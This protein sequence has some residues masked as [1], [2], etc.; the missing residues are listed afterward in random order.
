MITLEEARKK[1]LNAAGILNSEKVNFV[2]SLGMVLA[3][4]IHSPFNIPGFDRAAMDGYA[5]IS[6]DVADA[7][8]QNPV[9]L[10]MIADLPAGGTTSAKIKKDCCIRIMTGAPMPEGADAVVM[11]EDVKEKSCKVEK[12]E[13]LIFKDVKKE[14]NVAFAGEDV[15]KG[16]LILRRGTLIRAAQL[17]MLA[18]LGKTKVKVARKP[19]VAVIS[20][21]DEI[22]HPG[23]KLKSGQIYDSNSYGLCSQVLECGGEPY[24]LGIARD[25]K[26]ILLRKILEGLKFDI[27]L[28]SGGVSESVYD[29]VVSVLRKAGV[30]MLF[31]KVAVKPGKPTFFGK[32]GRT[33]VFGLPGYPVSSMLSF[34]SLVRPAILKI[35]G[36]NS[37]KKIKI[38]TI[39]KESIKNK[40]DRTSLIRVKLI[41]K[42]GEYCAIPAPS[43]KS[44]ALKS[45]VWANGI[46]SLSPGSEIKKGRE[47]SVELL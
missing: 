44:G 47:V 29:M 28:L 30:R 13:I 19:R 31:W 12:K 1:V 27:L 7:T 24:R 42:K 6:T 3:E 33:L 37:L 21:G 46:I 4:D 45:L 9:M 15:K 36:N 34:E 23:V 18:A 32:K 11:V 22:V 39:L 38:K 8:P 20:T 2:S 25:N 41:E 40:G 26:K 43:Q 10:R 17:A 35:L 14:E 5:V 16:E